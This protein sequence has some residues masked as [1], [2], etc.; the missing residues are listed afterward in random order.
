MSCRA[1]THGGR[2]KMMLAEDSIRRIEPDPSRSWQISLHPGMKRVLRVFGA[3]SRF[4]LPQVSA[5]QPH[6]QTMGSQRPRP[7]APQSPGRSLFASRAW[8]L[9]QRHLLLLGARSR[10]FHAA[11]CSWRPVLRRSAAARPERS[12]AGSA[13]GLKSRPPKRRQDG[14]LLR[15]ILE[16]Q[17]HRVGIEK[18][19]ETD[20][21]PG[22]RRR[23]QARSPVSSSGCG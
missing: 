3:A 5:R 21:T 16:R 23:I 10:C 22:A 19:I 9:E 6:S 15:T 2:Q 13:P 20:P 11:S 18:E 8:F 1:E 17:L 12:A 14:G 4:I 7:R